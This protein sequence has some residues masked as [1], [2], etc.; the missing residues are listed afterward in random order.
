MPQK[1]LN[2][3]CWGLLLGFQYVSASCELLIC[4]HLHQIFEFIL[5]LFVDGLWLLFKSITNFWFESALL[6]AILLTFRIRCSRDRLC[7]AVWQLLIK[8]QESNVQ[9]AKRFSRS[10]AYWDSISVTFKPIFISCQ[11]PACTRSLFFP[12]N[13]LFALPLCIFVCFYTL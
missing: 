1:C 13:F 5:L 7:C 11:L 9:A 10:Q 6:F 8:W 3:N 2:V 12:P 4:Q